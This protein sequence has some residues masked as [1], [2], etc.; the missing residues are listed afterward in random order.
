MRR[1][2]A[3]LRQHS[4]A[5][6]LSRSLCTSDHTGSFWS[7]RLSGRRQRGAC[8]DLPLVRLARGMEEREPGVGWRVALRSFVAQGAHPLQLPAARGRDGQG[9][10]YPAVQEGVRIFLAAL[11]QPELDVVVVAALE[12]K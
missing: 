1:E 6:I 8:T 5:S 11:R 7:A 3:R 10:L 9:V 4:R 2:E 12:G